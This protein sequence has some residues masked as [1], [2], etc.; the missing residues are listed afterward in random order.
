[1]PW[2]ASSPLCSSLFRL[3]GLHYLQWRGDASSS[4]PLPALVGMQQAFHWGISIAPRITLNIALVTCTDSCYSTYGFRGLYMRP[5]MQFCNKNYLESRHYFHV[6]RVMSHNEIMHTTYRLARMHTQP[7]FY[8]VH[9]TTARLLQSDCLFSPIEF[10]FHFVATPLTPVSYR[11][12][13]I[14]W[15]E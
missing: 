7:A 8:H 10:L 11:D 5:C 1:M 2:S 13:L 15:I 4:A 6:P 3:S 12:L 9:L 14:D